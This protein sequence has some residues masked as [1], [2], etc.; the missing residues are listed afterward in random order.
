MRFTSLC[1][2]SWFPKTSTGTRR[3]VFFSS[4]LPSCEQVK[5]TP[6]DKP[7]RR[8]S[9]QRPARKKERK[10]MK[11]LEEKIMAEPRHDDKKVACRGR[12]SRKAA[13]AMPRLESVYGKIA[14]WGARLLFVLLSCVFVGCKEKYE[15]PEAF[16]KHWVIGDLAKRKCP[17]ELMKALQ[18]KE[19]D[20]SEARLSTQGGETTVCATLRLVPDSDKTVYA[21]G[22]DSPSGI[23]ILSPA[24]FKEIVTAKLEMPR[25]KMDDGTFAPSDM[26]ME[27]AFLL[28]GW[29]R[30]G[31]LMV[32]NEE[33]V[34][35]LLRKLLVL[36]GTLQNPKTAQPNGE[37]LY[38]VVRRLAS[39]AD[40]TELD[41]IKDKKLLEELGDACTWIISLTANETDRNQFIRLF[42]EKTLNAIVAL[43]EILRARGVKMSGPK[44][45]KEHQE[46]VYRNT[47]IKNM[48]DI[49]DTAMIYYMKHGKPPATLADLSAGPEGEKLL[50]VIPTC[51]KDN[52]AYAI[53]RDGRK[54]KVTCG[55]GDPTHVR[56]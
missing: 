8:W 52:S 4:R 56:Q 43:T 35:E 44:D 27:S 26:K 49:L 19:I 47:C 36:A 28:Q 18:F 32:V 31:S 14:C 2:S 9:V 20:V 6:L 17:D 42:G 30:V 37:A 51:P 23:K 15:S 34:T 16:I 10:M 21:L 38:M 46:L 25:I 40:G 7:C 33:N 48:K 5:N 12:Q 29:G 54:I 1:V 45:A 53:S 39:Y 11:L 3:E 55:S 13:S 41:Y 24:E 50:D 22:A